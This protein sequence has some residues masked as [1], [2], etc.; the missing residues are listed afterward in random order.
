[1][2]SCAVIYGDNEFYDPLA[3]FV[4]NLFDISTRDGREHFLLP[5][6][7][8]YIQLVGEG[9]VGHGYV[10]LE[11]IQSFALGLNYREN[12]VDYALQ[13]A[14]S[15]KLV[16]KPILS[17]GDDGGGRYRITTVGAYADKRLVASFPYV[18]AV[19]VDTPIVDEDARNKIH[20]AASIFDRLVRAEEFRRYL[21]SQWQG[22]DA[23]RITFSWPQASSQLRSN[24]EDVTKR[25]KR[26]R[27]RRTT[28]LRTDS[29]SRSKE[30][31]SS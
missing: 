9:A 4:P 7:L 29:V 20:S 21:D 12:Q 1:M 27:D 19:V 18:D 26:R 25:A 10:G 2:S 3:S 16:E 13:R 8:A 14:E 22:F 17:A 6:L 24:I 28:S 5:L 15:K 23:D 11:D 31:G 30:P